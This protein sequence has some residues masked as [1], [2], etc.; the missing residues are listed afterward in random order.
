MKQTGGRGVSLPSG[1]THDASAMADLCPIIM[2][3]VRSQ[4]GISHKP[5]EFTAPEDMN[6]AIDVLA[7]F[8]KIADQK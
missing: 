6:T 4:D 8:L 1:A 5:E 3:F 7:R 2:L